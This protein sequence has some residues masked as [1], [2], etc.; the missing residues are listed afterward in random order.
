MTAVASR[1]RFFDHEESFWG[2]LLR[3]LS[4]IIVSSLVASIGLVSDAKSEKTGHHRSVERDR[5]NAPDAAVAD[6]L[7]EQAEEPVEMVVGSPPMVSD[8]TGTPGNG[9]W[10]INVMLAGDISKDS[11][12]FELPLMDINYGIGD[13]LQLKY[14]VPYVVS[15]NAGFSETGEGRTQQASGFSNSRVGL[16][17]RFYDN[18]RSG[19]SLGVYP[20][21]EFRT[22]GSKLEGEP[23]EGGEGG[24]AEEGVTY[25]L[26]IL[27]T[28]EFQRA[29]IT[30]ISALKERHK[31]MVSASPQV[32]VLAH[33]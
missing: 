12:T 24:V 8:D 11:K 30:T 17:Y 2:N 23:D 20:Q 10:E 9:N 6:S 27:L 1:S 16:K 29:P 19:L 22:P 4:T 32:L 7:E 25:T 15:W 5:R 21:V 14:E 3:V 18:D 13:R 33:A 28:K 26:P 31:K